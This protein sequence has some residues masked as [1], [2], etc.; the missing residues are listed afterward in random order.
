MGKKE[1]AQNQSQS[2]GKEE[3][4]NQCQL[5]IKEDT[6]Y[7]AE[8]EKRIS[9][10]DDEGSDYKERVRKIF[11]IK[12]L[13]GSFAEML[14]KVVEDQRSLAKPYNIPG[15][16]RGIFSNMFARIHKTEKQ[17]E[18][19]N[20]L[21]ARVLWVQNREAIDRLLREHSPDDDYAIAKRMH[22]AIHVGQEARSI[23]DLPG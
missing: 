15:E 19:L 14:V 12:D 4:Q 6:Q 9:E 13:N 21:A 1:E 8:F 18:I 2:P 11:S 20:I 5:T 23:P 10:Q 7:L 16:D 22:I 3:V 17:N